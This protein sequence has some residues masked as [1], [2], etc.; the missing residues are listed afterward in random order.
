MKSLILFV[1]FFISYQIVFSQSFKDRAEDNVMLNIPTSKTY[2]TA[3]IAKYIT[4]N[5]NT[6][7][8]RVFAIYSWVTANIQYDTDSANIINMGPDPEAKITAALRRRK[9]VCENYAAIF[10]DICLKTGLTGFVVDGYTKQYNTVDKVAHSW[11]AVYFDNSWHLCDPTW[12]AAVAGNKYFLASPSYMI[13]THMPFDP[14][15]QLSEH[16]ISHKQFVNGTSFFNEENQLFNYKD[17]IAAYITMDSLQKFRTVAS[18]I[19]KSGLY[20]NMIRSRHELAKMNIEII[21][22]DKDVALYNAAVND[23]NTTTMIYNDFVQ[24][25]N[26]LF[27]PAISDDVLKISLDSIE[28]KILNAHKKLDDI[29]KSEATFKFSVDDVRAKLYSL[30]GKIKTQKDFLKR[31]LATPPANRKLLFYSTSSDG[32]K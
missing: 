4:E 32:N 24:F 28:D 26:R 18:R 6:D 3:S 1:I 30:A 11:C 5:C 12:D 2:S 25:R 15:W 17:S 21:R 13:Q 7:R 27:T 29:E 23:L 10:N 22:E 9:G 8:E 16:P 31:Y 20:N 14:M 19:E